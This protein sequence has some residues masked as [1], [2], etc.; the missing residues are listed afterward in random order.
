PGIA[1][2]PQEHD[3]APA[4]RSDSASG[5]PGTEP[6]IV[7]P[8]KGSRKSGSFHRQG[9]GGTMSTQ[10][11]ARGIVFWDVDTQFDFMTPAEEGGKLYVKEAGDPTDEGARR[12]VPQLER[13]SR[14][15]R[16]HGILRVAT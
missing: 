8:T 2:A 12:I 11:S 6:R 15:A 9:S 13:L 7:G 3:S 10:E 4:G 5:E 14:Y 16:E 1:R